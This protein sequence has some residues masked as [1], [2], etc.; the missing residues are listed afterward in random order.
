[1]I[2]SMWHRENLYS[3]SRV[4]TSYVRDILTKIGSGRDQD[5]GGL[6]DFL[7][8]R[9]WGGEP[10]PSRNSG[11]VGMPYAEFSSIFPGLFRSEKIRKNLGKSGKIEG[12]REKLWEIGKNRGKSGKIEENRGK[13]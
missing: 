7:T 1:M 4:Y 13:S 11:H 3:V 9:D 5:R 6:P 10:D 8:N 2:E 12:N